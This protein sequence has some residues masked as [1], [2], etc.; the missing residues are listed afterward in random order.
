MREAKSSYLET[1]NGKLRHELDTLQE[2]MK[3]LKDVIDRKKTVK[4]DPA[5]D[6]M[7]E[8]NK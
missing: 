1:E 5:D 8:E 3:Q 4:P 7:P 6:D 2:E